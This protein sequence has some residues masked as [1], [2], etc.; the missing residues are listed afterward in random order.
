MKSFMSSPTCSVLSKSDNSE[1][2]FKLLEQRFSSYVQAIE[3]CKTNRYKYKYPSK[4]DVDEELLENK[5]KKHII[6]RCDCHGANCPNERKLKFHSTGQGTFEIL[7]FERGLHSASSS[8]P[9]MRGIDSRLLEFIDNLYRQGKSPREIRCAVLR[10]AKAGQWGMIDDIVFPTLKQIYNRKSSV[11]E[12]QSHIA[13]ER[14][15][16]SAKSITSIPEPTAATDDDYVWSSDGFTPPFL[17]SAFTNL[18]SSVATNKDTLRIATER[19]PDSANSITSIPEPTAATDDDYVWSSDG[20]TPPFLA[21]AFTNLSSSVA[22]NKDTLR[23]A[24]ERFPDSANS[25]T[26]IPEPTAT[27]DDDYVWSSDGITPPFLASTFT[28]LS[29]SAASQDSSSSI[30]SIPEPKAT[31]KDDEYIWSSDEFNTSP[32]STLAFLTSYAIA[33]TDE[34]RQN[35]TLKEQMK[36]QFD[37]NSIKEGFLA[38][39]STQR[40]EM[41]LQLQM[42]NNFKSLN[43]QPHQIRLEEKPPAPKKQKLRNKVTY[44]NTS[45]IYNDDDD[46]EEVIYRDP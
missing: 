40:F 12:S 33:T 2:R 21:S 24:T 39:N 44:R 15:P 34:A 43:E 23:I 13:T 8:V 37:F 22:T 25:I 41:I 27:T 18:S 31:T 20:F 36:T 30:N 1:K 19:F 10:Q 29:F 6:Y 3:W 4:T 14:F 35:S 28:N 11:K 32:D 16:D 9:K 46:E 5:T 26:S 42:L 38:Y 7:M 17:A 45:C